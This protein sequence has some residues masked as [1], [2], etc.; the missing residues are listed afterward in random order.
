[1]A[2]APRGTSRSGERA[3]AKRL[4]D[5]GSKAFAPGIN[6]LHHERSRRRRAA[7]AHQRN[8]RGALL[9]RRLNRRGSGLYPAIK[10]REAFS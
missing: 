7:L 6:D 3:L 9:P 1:M 8:A 2:P 4:R 10:N 5:A